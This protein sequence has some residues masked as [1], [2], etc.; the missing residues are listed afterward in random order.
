MYLITQFEC[1]LNG[2]HKENP[3]CDCGKN[4]I[5]HTCGFGAGCI[6]CDC[7]RPIIL[8]IN[9]KGDLEWQREQILGCSSG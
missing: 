7:S 2:T 3:T 8:G 4:R 5:C 9:P 1:A 6:P